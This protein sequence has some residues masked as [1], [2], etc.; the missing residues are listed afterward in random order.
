M[1]FVSGMMRKE[2]VD[3]IVLLLFWGL[4]KLGFNFVYFKETNQLQT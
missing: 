4:P 2:N 3:A 1:A